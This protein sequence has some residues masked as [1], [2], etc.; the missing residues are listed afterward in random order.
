M[1]AR[2]SVNVISRMVSHG[3]DIISFD[4]HIFHCQRKGRFERVRLRLKADP[5]CLDKGKTGSSSESENGN[6]WRANH[7]SKAQPPAFF[8]PRVENILVAAPRTDHQHDC[9]SLGMGSVRPLVHRR[10]IRVGPG[11][12]ALEIEY[13]LRYAATA[14]GKA[15]QSLRHQVTPG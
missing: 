15:F 5:D 13:H 4:N 1:I 7:A 6:E 3:L 12:P 14:L 10:K 11:L 8:P 2:R 9:L